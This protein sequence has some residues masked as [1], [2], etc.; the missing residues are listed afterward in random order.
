MIFA[1][2][3]SLVQQRVLLFLHPEAESTTMHYC[4]CLVSVLCKRLILGFAYPKQ[5][6]F[7]RDV[8]KESMG[9]S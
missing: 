4:K 3:G 5:I 9:S 7:D 1:L 8:V 2:I 6:S